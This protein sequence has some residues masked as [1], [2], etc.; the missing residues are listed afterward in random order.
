VTSNEN[1]E[2]RRLREVSSVKVWLQIASADT[3]GWLT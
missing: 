2:H 1:C 3:E